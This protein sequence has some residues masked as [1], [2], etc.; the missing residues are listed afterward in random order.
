MTR[1]PK[2]G[3]PWSTILGGS[4]SPRGSCLNMPLLLLPKSQGL[5]NIGR[6]DFILNIWEV[7]GFEEGT[8]QIKMEMNPETS[9]RLFEEGATFVFT[10]VPPG[11]EV[12]IDMQ[13]WNAGEKFR[14]IK[15]IPPG[16]HFMFF[17]AVNKEGNVAP[18]TG[19]FH[20]FEK[21]QVIVRKYDPAAEDISRMELSEDTVN[22]FKCSLKSMDQ[23]LGA[24][25]Y[26]VWRKWVSLTN[27]LTPEILKRLSPTSGRILSAPELILD[28]DQSEPPGDPK[29]TKLEEAESK[30]PKMTEEPSCRINYTPIPTKVYP[31]GATPSEIS[32]HSVDDSF[33]F[34]LFL[35]SYTKPEEFLAELQF[36]FVNFLVG[37]NYTSFEQWKSLVKLITFS[38]SAI[39]KYQSIYSDFLSDLYFQISNVDADFFSDIVTSKF[40]WIFEYEECPEDE[41]PVVVD[42]STLLVGFIGISIITNSNFHGVD[43][44]IVKSGGLSGE[45]FNCIIAPPL[46]QE[47]RPNS[48][49]IFESLKF[50]IF[51]QNVM[52]N[53]QRATIL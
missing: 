10:N 41:Q 32:R 52:E 30:L 24:Y 8:L 7:F 42:L 9:L 34:E 53:M 44:L 46:I 43:D 11:T 36:A 29:R 21:G 17:S 39:L 37:Q 20:V 22:R 5:V 2:R 48:F 51:G 35:S 19:F 14:G 33:R 6:A 18:R 16:I 25:P 15:M 1:G 26:D 38:E 49:R 50:K 27:R 12:G 3:I 28:E 23:Y 4:L 31:D 47:N 40:G 45:F 13:S